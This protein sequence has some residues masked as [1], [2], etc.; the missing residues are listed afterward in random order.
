MTIFSHLSYLQRNRFAPRQ[1]IGTPSNELAMVVVIPCFAE[2]HLL[3][4]LNSLEKCDLPQGKVEILIVINGSEK[5]SAEQMQK[6]EQ[7]L[8]DFQA[9]NHKRKY[10]YHVLHFPNL[11]KKH[12]GV[13]L[14][15][16]IGMDEALDRLQQVDNEK[17][18]IV[19][20]DA[21]SLVPA[22][23]LVEIEQYFLRYPKTKAASIHFEHPLSNEEIAALSPDAPQFSPEV[24]AGI[25]RYE[26]YLRY[27]IEGLKYAGYPFAYH[28]IGSSMVARADIYAAE[29]GM[30]RKQAGEDFYFLHKIIPLGNFGEITATQV[31]PSPRPSEKVP[32][33]TGR[34]IQNWLSNPEEEYPCY[35]VQIF[36]DLR[37]FLEKVPALYVSEERNFPPSIQAFCDTLKFEEDLAENK[38]HSP[39]EKTFIKRFFRWFDGFMILKYVH[40][41]RD[42]FYTNQPLQTMAADLWKMKGEKET[43][44]TLTE[45]LMTYRACQR[46]K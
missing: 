36:E 30:N 40:F 28:T 27:Y 13:G 3:S 7:T 17:G 12:A 26:L 9:W 19:C 43:F 14:A 10:V 24:Y 11:P 29:G 38:K 45:A 37:L 32:F 23:Y 1:I 42:N 35:N 4:T 8:K 6:N 5:A 2:T 33:G 16:K 15:R 22:N 25:L 41:A 39:N 18:I 44:V 21:D 34:A 31:Y 20:L 46:K